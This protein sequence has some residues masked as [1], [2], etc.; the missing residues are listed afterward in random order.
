NRRRRNRLAAHNRCGEYVK[1]GVLRDEC[2]EGQGLC[3]GSWQRLSQFQK[4]VAILWCIVDA[5]A[6]PNNRLSVRRPRQPHAWAE[7][8]PIGFC[9]RS[10]TA[11]RAAQKERRAVNALLSAG[12]D[13]CRR[14]RGREIDGR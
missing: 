12:E 8:I 13:R 11:A 10:G 6:G 3:I 14:W 5:C 1:V 2:V 4:S 9:T 7:V